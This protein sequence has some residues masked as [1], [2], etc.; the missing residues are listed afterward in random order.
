MKD[1][2]FRTTES[3]KKRSLIIP[4]I[5]WKSISNVKEFCLCLWNIVHVFV[6]NIIII[7]FL[8][9]TSMFWLRFVYWNNIFQC[10]LIDASKSQGTSCKHWLNLPRGEMRQHKS[11]FWLA[12]M[13]FTIY[14]PTKCNW[15][16]ITRVEIQ[17]LPI[18][19]RCSVVTT[20]WGRWDHCGAT[21]AL[22]ARPCLK[23]CRSMDCLN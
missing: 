19:S 9:D 21:T 13:W 17:P 10:N 11:G 7:Y 20:R 5:Q 3:I 23:Q 22:T 16:I 12:K 14:S 18:G 6:K 15:P 2:N 4:H 8:Y 1:F